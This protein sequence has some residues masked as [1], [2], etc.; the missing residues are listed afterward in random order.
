M[1]LSIDQAN[2][3]M[4]DLNIPR[5]LKSGSV[6]DVLLGFCGSRIAGHLSSRRRRLGLLNDGDELLQAGENGPQLGLK[7]ELNL[8]VTQAV[9]KEEEPVELC[10]DL[11]TQQGNV[12]CRR[13]AV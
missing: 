9:D 7:A 6:F 13:G 4:V 1:G 3:F 5:V 12:I 11:A 2:H 8:R 10:H